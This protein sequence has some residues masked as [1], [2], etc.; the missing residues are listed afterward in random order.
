M[1]LVPSFLK[2]I[3]RAVDVSVTVINYTHLV[4][5]TWS[6]LLRN[7]KL[8]IELVGAIAE[9]RNQSDQLDGC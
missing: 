8:F 9:V 1:K 4:K 6:P 5:N 2:P 3:Q 7:I